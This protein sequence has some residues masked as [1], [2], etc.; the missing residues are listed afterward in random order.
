MDLRLGRQVGLLVGVDGTELWCRW[1]TVCVCVG[2]EVGGGDIV[3]GSVEEVC[4][5]FS[6]SN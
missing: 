2:V 1:T 4:N 5:G 6:Y 3:L